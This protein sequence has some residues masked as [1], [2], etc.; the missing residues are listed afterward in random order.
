MPD[1]ATARLRLIALGLPAAEERETWNQPTWRVRGRMFAL[2][3]ADGGRI[4]VWL[5]AP[6]GAQAVLVGA[7][8]ERFFAPPYLGGRGWVG[9][10]LHGR[11]DWNEVAALVRR[12]FRLVAPKR[13]AALV[14]DAPG[15]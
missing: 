7:D 2:Q 3:S 12:S 4:A 8:P 1:R 10:R 13:L 5:K 14:S 15:C 9:M 6:P 11:P